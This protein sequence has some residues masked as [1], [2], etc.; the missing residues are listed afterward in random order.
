MYNEKFAV[1]DL[2]TTGN[3]RDKDH[4]IQ[5]SIVFID[6]LTIT[7]Q[8]TT[9]LSDD[10]NLSPF[11]REL[12]SIEP[13][14]LK[15]AP[16]FADVAH[17]I[18]EMLDKYTFVAHNVDFDLNFLQKHF[19][20]ANLNYKPLNAI[21][22]VE[23]A[24]IFL[25]ALEKFQLNEI[26][27]SLGIELSNAHRAD[28]D[29]RATAQVLLHVIGKM[30]NTNTDTLKSLYHL[31][32]K[33][34]FDLNALLFSIIADIT[35]KA[36]DTLISYG[37][38]YIKDDTAESAVMKPMTVDE[39]YREYIDRTDEVYRED[40]IVLAR[41]LFHHFENHSHLAT[42]AYTGLGKTT[43]FL[44][45]ALSYQSLYKGK[46][47]IS[48]SRKILQNQ[49]MNTQ[50]NQLKEGLRIPAS[51]A[52][53]KGKENYL[54]LTAFH[55]LLELEDDNHEITLLKMRLLVWLLETDTGDLSEI[56][57][58]GPERSY[59]RTMLIQSGNKHE[60]LFF[61]RALDNAVKADLTFTNHYFL[62]DSL[63][64]M[65]DVDVLIVDE[66]HKLKESLT[67]RYKTEF[68]YQDMK[69]FVGQ[70]GSPDQNRLLTSY[71]DKNQD[72]SAY[73]LEDLL[74]Q[75]NQNVDR[76]YHAFHAGNIDS[77]LNIIEKDIHYTAVF[78]GTIRGT[79]DY[80]PLYNHVHF[81]QKS[82]EELKQGLM[83]ENYTLASDEN[84]Q[85]IKVSISHRDFSEF[86][87]LINDLNSLVLMSGTLEVRGEFKHL[88]EL[89]GGLPY[90]SR[91]ISHPNL[92]DQTTLFIP[93]DIPKYNIK[94]A[95]YIYAV[96]EYISIYLTETNGK[97]M[98]LFSNYELLEAIHDF[99]DEVGTFE[100]FAVLKQSKSTP[101]DKLLAQ[102][103][104]LDHALLLAT[105]SFTEGINLEGTADKCIAMTKLPFPVPDESGYRSFHKND[106]P[107]AVFRFRQII[108]RVVRQPEERGII[109]LLDNRIL[110]KNYKNAF[111]KYFP[112]ENIKR[113]GRKAFK[114]FLSDL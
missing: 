26:T 91:I 108:G 109:L 24:K 3:N 13:E 54:D 37:A 9:F 104:Q 22:T 31:S 63:E 55:D 21:D 66:A 64:R 107:E 16:K 41:E 19:A 6:N 34:R 5:L 93:D 57:L 61:N 94:D 51:A 102:Y 11:I 36:D 85:R 71:I 87:H 82:L 50:F 47:L 103:N 40:Q 97:M 4:I 20:D 73:L 90:T 18:F 105:A 53:F 79:H 78:L 72:V 59:Y 70:V 17:D 84:I 27:Q 8:Y 114:G 10:K 44:I 49:M 43:A 106:L 65:E 23:L 111:L 83:D 7:S 100:D 60:N 86:H 98:V 68:N 48:T 38:F 52:N 88:D 29:A 80:Q 81:Y 89:F 58:R 39:M 2:E 62:S 74:N 15:G 75:L 112:S 28:E 95:E 12:T 35:T 1:V 99:I 30:M 67:E 56:G 42:E 92:Y 14:M 46:V 33:L 25:P 77:A 101:P 110:S 113:G 69:F 76:L 96:I 32:K 45:A